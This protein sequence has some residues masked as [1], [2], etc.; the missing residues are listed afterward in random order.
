M[1][2]QL[3]E[4]ARE[5]ARHLSVTKTSVKNRGFSRALTEHSRDGGLA[6]IAEVKPRSPTTFHAD[7]SPADA[8]ELAV[9]YRRLGAT[10]VSVLTEPEHFGGSTR[11][12][13]AVRDAVDVPV[14]RKDFI[15]AEKQMDEVECDAILLITR[16]LGKRLGEMVDA[17]LERGIEPMV[18]THSEGELKEALKTGTLLVGVNNRDLENLQMDTNTALRL[19]PGVRDS[20]RVFVAESGIE[21]ASQARLYREAGAHAVLVGNALMRD[22]GLLTLLRGVKP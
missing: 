1:L 11:H 15:V 5:R 21:D 6:V 12:L 3:V 13:R 9:E 19:L 14:L 22:P 17:A 18:E 16:A 10:A 8:A 4:E 2:G 20:G 7:I